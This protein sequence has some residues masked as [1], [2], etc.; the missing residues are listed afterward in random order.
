MGDEE[1]REREKR[2]DKHER[3]GIKKGIKT[4]WS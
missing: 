3:E 4:E 2:Q 1:F